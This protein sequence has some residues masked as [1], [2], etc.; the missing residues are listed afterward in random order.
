MK[1]RRLILILILVLASF[2]AAS[3]LAATINTNIPGTAPY[4][5]NPGGWVAN[6]YQFAL[7]LGGL[8]AFGAIVYGGITYTLSAGNPE[9]Q[10]DAKS[11][12]TQA[13][14][15]LTLLL[16][17]YLVLNFLNPKL[18]VLELDTYGLTAAC[19]GTTCE[20]PVPLDNSLL[21]EIAEAE[22]AHKQA[23]ADI[24]EADRLDAEARRLLDE[25]KYVSG[26]EAKVFKQEALE[27][28]REA[29]T[30]RAEAVK[31]VQ[32]QQFESAA[33]NKDVA[34]MQAH[35]DVIVKSFDA[36]SK[37]LYRNGDVEGAATL[38]FKTFEQ[39]TNLTARITAAG[40]AARVTQ[41]N[42]SARTE[43]TSRGGPS[44]GAGVSGASQVSA[45]TEGMMAKIVADTD[46]R[47]SSIERTDPAR[48]AAM[49]KIAS[50][51]VATIKE[52]CKGQNLGCK[53]YVPIPAST[54]S[55]RPGTTPPATTPSSI[56]LSKPL[57]PN[58]GR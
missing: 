57:A 1:P 20:K 30:F 49:R 8:L 39:D 52:S 36:A 26:P 14:L 43:A 3:A 32:S 24:Q 40:L 27:A 2:S 51:A 55:L 44:V 47:A 31:K 54:P 56:D 4:V 16:G 18:T 10:S 19:K 22:A 35:K 6:F 23:Q 41:A 34:A 28:L 58:T 53:S 37:E 5:N 21:R 25:L 29:E 15:G 11:R 17:A 45:A 9:K 7:L 38:A 42:A 46:A 50:D 48:A 33:R 13:L 12:I